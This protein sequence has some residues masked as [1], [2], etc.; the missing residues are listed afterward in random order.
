MKRFFQIVWII[1][2]LTSLNFS[3]AEAKPR[4]QA[5]KQEVIHLDI[6]KTEEAKSGRFSSLKEKETEEELKNDALNDNIDKEFSIF[7]N[8]VDTDKASEHPFKIEEESLFGRIYKK[9]HLY[10]LIFCRRN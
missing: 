2:I 5:P 10:P 7:D 4:K 1:F 3:A 9:E 8:L 6:E